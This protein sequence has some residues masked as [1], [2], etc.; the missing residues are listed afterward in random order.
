MKGAIATFV[1]TPGLSQVKTRLAESIG[2]DQAEEFFLLSVSAIE[3]VIKQ[4]AEQSKGRLT[5][6]WAVAEG[7]AVD[8]QL[9]SG[10]K[11]IHTGR[12]GLGHRLDNIYSALIKDYD[13]VILLGAD[14]PQITPELIIS[15]IDCFKKGDDFVIGPAEDGGFYLFAGKAP[16][17]SEFWTRVKYSQDDTLHNLQKKLPEDSSVAYLRKL[18]DVDTLENLNRLY[19]QIDAMSLPKQLTIKEWIK[20]TIWK[21]HSLTGKHQFN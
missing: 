4:A 12:G 13:F 21:K 18:V 1:K 8:N 7:R 16:I 2:S 3:E 10:F 14:S 15:V 5:P 6:F 20:S 19:Y 9:W 11:S 17:D